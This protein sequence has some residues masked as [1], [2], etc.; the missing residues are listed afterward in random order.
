MVPVKQTGK[1]GNGKFIYLI[2]SLTTQPFPMK[3]SGLI[4]I[5]PGMVPVKKKRGK[6]G[7][8][9]EIYISYRLLSY[10]TDPDETFRTYCDHVRDGSCEK[11]NG[12]NREREI[13]MSYRLLNYPTVPN[14]TFRTYCDHARDGSCEKK[15]R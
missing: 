9:T 13:Y 14:E 15:K 3:L 10:A 8:G 6:S 5:M 11:K 1:I 4:V 7:T 12:E 2:G